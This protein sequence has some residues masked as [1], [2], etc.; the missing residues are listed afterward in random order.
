MYRLA[1]AGDYVVVLD[2]NNTPVAHI[3]AENGRVPRE[4]ETL[5]DNANTWLSIEENKSSMDRFH[6]MLMLSRSS[7]PANDGG[8]KRFVEEE[9]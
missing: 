9:I 1:R 2:D 4:I 8:F 6:M 5:V 3:R 7:G